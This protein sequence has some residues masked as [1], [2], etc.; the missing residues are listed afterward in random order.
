[1][2]AGQAQEGGQ[3]IE[4]VSRVMIQSI[5]SRGDIQP[6]IALGVAL[7][8][9]GFRV[10]I[11]T[12]KNHI[13]FVESMGLE[14]EGLWGDFETLMRE[15]P[16]CLQ[17]MQS[18]DF[19]AL[20]KFLHSEDQRRE[21]R[22]SVPLYMNAFEKF[23]PQLV[24]AGTML[25]WFA[26][27][28]KH[29]YKVPVIY[30]R[31]SGVPFDGSRSPLGLPNLPFGLAKTMMRFIV[32][33]LWFEDEDF[34][35]RVCHNIGGKRLYGNNGDA[36]FP[37]RE[38]EDNLL[39]KCSEKFDL[40]A[41]SEQAADILATGRPKEVIPTGAWVLDETDQL[42]KATE[43]ETEPNSNAFGGVEAFERLKSFLDTHKEEGV[44]YL[45]WGSMVS[46]TPA[47]MT[48]FALRT[49]KLAGAPGVILGGF[50]RLSPSLLREDPTPAAD[51]AE[52]LEF[53][54]T[55]GRVRF[56]R[57]AP[58]E[59]L[60]PRCAVV[61][62]HGGAGTTMA[63]LRSGSPVV[64]TPVF[65]DQFDHAYLVEK[66]RCGHGLRQLQRLQASD[67]SECLRKILKEGKYAEYKERAEEVARKERG[68]GGLNMA[69]DLL[70]EFCREEVET[71]EWHK[72]LEERHAEVRAKSAEMK[73]KAGTSHSFRSLSVGVSVG[74][75]A[76]AATAAAAM[77]L[78]IGF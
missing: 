27:L 26:A 6:F 18:G 64:I 78:E 34:D 77:M 32:R 68:E 52:L 76:V 69:C 60:F 44:V 40:L 42:A 72:R 74:A 49:L 57:S 46:G 70:Q 54:E 65:A 62:H 50:A 28:A 61:V 15:D 21:L 71:G 12:N 14:G 63:S 8:R 7:K 31:L 58:H 13:K 24:V 43:K 25:F 39:R 20:M 9:R 51:D 1:M 23:N 73:G 75:L 33:K 55:S 38:M 59:W 19:L 45:G 5:G 36:F 48:R 10:S 37:V 29:H 11:F 66:L 2:T 41:I 3:E 16:H 47:N 67:L 4:K 17:A 30:G 22:E 56:A 35:K 53:A